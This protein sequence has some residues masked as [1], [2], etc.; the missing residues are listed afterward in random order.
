MATH[1]QADLDAAFA[2]LAYL[3]GE[4]EEDG[5]VPCRCTVCG[6]YNF[7]HAARTCDN[8]CIDC[9]CV[10]YGLRL[11]YFQHV[12]N[13]A[14][15]PTNY[16]RIHHFHERISQLM[17]HESQIP[18][19]E[20]ELIRQKFA[21]STYT[22]I[23][24]DNIRAVL[25]SLKMQLYIEKWLQIIYR[26]TGIRP[27]MPG[28]QLIS[29]LDQMFLELQRPFD[30]HKTPTRKNFLNY[31][32]I[33][34]R[35]FQK[36]KCSQFCMFFPL[37]KSKQKLKN[38]DQMWN[39]MASSVMWEVTPL[40]HVQPFAVTLDAPSLLRDTR[41]PQNALSVLVEQHT[42]QSKRGFQTSDHP[43]EEYNWP[44]LKLR[45]SDQ[46]ALQS[47]R[48]ANRLVHSRYI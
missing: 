14:I 33:F 48:Y 17:L 42:K 12:Y 27:P 9:G 35:L 20:F 46:L 16:K 19:V 38:L 24:K 43:H 39:T 31:N 23:N 13:N 26:L 36:M 2:D 28:P 1:S 34:C 45:R 30:A 21:E 40:E 8:V 32:Y 15:H 10:H 5:N 37:I 4:S 11:P 22:V 47:R 25:R 3:L 7:E 41:A 29:M 44:S 6:S 18:D